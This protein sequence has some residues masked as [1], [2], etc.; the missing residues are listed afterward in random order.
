MQ[1][2]VNLSKD[3]SPVLN[4][5]QSRGRSDN[6][7]MEGKDGIRTYHDIVS[8]HLRFFTS[9]LLTLQLEAAKTNTQTHLWGPQTSRSGV[10]GYEKTPSV[11][12]YKMSQTLFKHHNDAYL[13]GN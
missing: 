11:K 6:Y 1:N 7:Q 10:L 4:P 8:L 2:S 9:Q 5:A 12:V 13:R 3:C